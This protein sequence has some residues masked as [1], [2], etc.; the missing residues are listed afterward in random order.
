MLAVAY[1]LIRN[2]IGPKCIPA[3]GV[4][5]LVVVSAVHADAVLCRRRKQMRTEKDCGMVQR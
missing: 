4:V 3:I 5:K 1:L 2:L